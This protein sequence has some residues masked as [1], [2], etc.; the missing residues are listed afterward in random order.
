MGRVACLVSWA[1]RL[2]GTCDGPEVDA[3]FEEERLF[4]F[5]GAGGGCGLGTCDVEAEWG[6]ESRRDAAEAGGRGLGVTGAESSADD[7]VSVW[8][9]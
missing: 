7:A 8:G 1:G 6:E 9:G 4:D 2:S 5:G 3:M